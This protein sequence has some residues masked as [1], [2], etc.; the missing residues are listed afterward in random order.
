M[1]RIAVI[2]PLGAGRHI[3]AAA[4]N[5]E[6]V[7]GFQRAGRVG[8]PGRVGGDREIRLFVLLAAWRAHRLMMGAAPGESRALASP[9]RRAPK[10]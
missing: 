2:K 8:R 4:E 9:S 7:V 3:A 1:P 5:R 6:T 10:P